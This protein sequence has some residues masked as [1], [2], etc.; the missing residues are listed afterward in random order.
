MAELAA[1]SACAAT[2]GGEAAERSLCKAASTRLGNG[3]VGVLYA[4]QQ[5]RAAIVK[6]AN[7]GICA[8]T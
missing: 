6:A 8:H 5:M 2:T 3:R 1:L 7:I 4:L